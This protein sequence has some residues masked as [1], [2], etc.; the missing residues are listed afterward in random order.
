M[1]IHYHRTESVAIDW[2]VDPVY[3]D[4]Q[5][6]NISNATG[7]VLTRIRDGM[8]YVDVDQREHC[9][10]Q[11]SE[12]TNLVLH[13]AFYRSSGN[14]VLGNDEY[15]ITVTSPLKSDTLHQTLLDLALYHNFPDKFPF[16]SPLAND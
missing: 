8:G 15:I 10:M 5:R 2:I 1:L 7:D 9:P 6:G 12:W 3:H 11:K 13:F 14:V 4:H 16:S